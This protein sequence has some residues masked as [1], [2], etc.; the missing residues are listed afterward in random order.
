MGYS[1]WGCKELDTTEQ[2]TLS[3][4]FHRAPAPHPPHED[5]M[6]NWPSATSKRALTRT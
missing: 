1:T 5:A 6:R 3:P 4:L 2:L